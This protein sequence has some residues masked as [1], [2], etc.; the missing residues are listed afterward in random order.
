MISYINHTLKSKTEISRPNWVTFVLISTSFFILDKTF[1]SETT[2]SKI[3]NLLKK[4]K[5]VTQ[6]A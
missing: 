5:G 4:T 3:F 6:I 2:M 1:D